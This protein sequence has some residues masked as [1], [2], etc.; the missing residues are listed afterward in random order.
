[1]A[2]GKLTESS[3]T[4]AETL[5]VEALTYLASDPDRLARFLQESGLDPAAIRA[6]AESPHFLLAVVEHVMSDEALLLEFARHA[7]I[8]PAALARARA[9]LG[10][11]AWERDVP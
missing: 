9:V 5:A 8:D 6:A 10:G 1:M 4:A 2:R 7:G 11:P 3:R